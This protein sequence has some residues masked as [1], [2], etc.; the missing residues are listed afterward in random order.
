MRISL[1]TGGLALMLAGALVFGATTANAHERREV[2]DYTFIVGFLNEPALLNEPN[3][4]DL[5]ISNTETEEPIEGLEET[6]SVTVSAQGQDMELD[7]GARFNTPGAYNG[8]FMPTSE[9][10]YTFHV[11][12]TIEGNEIDETFSS[13][14]DTFSNVNAP[15]GFPF[16]YG[17]GESDGASGLEE[18]V[19][20][21]EDDS[22]GGGSGATLGIIGIVLGGLGLA[23][24][25]LAFMRGSKA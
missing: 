17:E 6:L 4:L 5:R 19:S 2:G 1:V 14:P 15:V 11:T 18:R 8:Y 12:G 9:G 21:L 3:S 24:G 16:A 13:G 23:V 22:D 10:E 20:A 7:L 25:G